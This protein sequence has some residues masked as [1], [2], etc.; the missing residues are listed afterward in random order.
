MST[1][2][3][4]FAAAWLGFGAFA[5]PPDTSLVPR[6]DPW[7]DHMK[8]LGYPSNAEVCKMVTNNDKDS[9]TKSKASDFFATWMIE[10]G[11]K[12][13]DWVQ[14]M[15]K[16]ATGKSGVTPGD[17]DCTLLHSENCQPPGDGDCENYN[18][19]AFQ[20][21]QTQVVNLY[22]ILQSMD[23]ATIKQTLLQDLKIGELIRDFVPE[24]DLANTKKK[25]SIAAVVM[26]IVSGIFAVSGLGAPAGLAIGSGALVGGLTTLTATAGIGGF[27][28]NTL[29]AVLSITST[30]LT[31]GA[32]D[33]G[34]ME[35]QLES[36][37]GDF[38]QSVSDKNA[39]ITA[40]V[41]GG[42][43]QQ[44]VD[45]MDF[46]SSIDNWYDRFRPVQDFTAIMFLLQNGWFLEQAH[47]L[48]SIQ[49]MFSA[50]FSLMKVGLIGYLYNARKFYVMH[51][52]KLDE[53]TCNKK[54]EGASRF[55]DGG[56]FVLKIGGKCIN[57]DDNAPTELKRA[58]EKYKM[59][60]DNFFRNVRDCNNNKGLIDNKAYSMDKLGEMGKCFFPLNYLHVETP[61]DIY[62]V[63]QTVADQLGLKYPHYKNGPKGLC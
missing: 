61:D 7:A 14:Q 38:F 51:Y 13:D 23:I 15:H 43:P 6:G 56:C 12:I 55:V 34:K 20:V 18:P 32:I 57:H 58:E 22:S 49:P 37:L 27:A 33:A 19:A 1:I 21:I 36:K 46:V 3:T 24:S 8:K 29:G 42:K 9:W 25:L 41:F 26:W 50:G 63:N 17:L 5:Y 60:L 40:K 35:D 30:S 48:Q 59:K 2:R 54:Y 47:T 31:D 62:K 52:T 39:A 16:N 10:H 53:Q 4:L 44:K 28:F 11:N 45:L